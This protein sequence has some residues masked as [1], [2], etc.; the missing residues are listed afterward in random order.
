[1]CDR[2]DLALSVQFSV[3]ENRLDLI[4]DIW[5]LC[6]MPETGEFGVRIHSTL[7]CELGETL[8]ELGSELAL[9]DGSDSRCRSRE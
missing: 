5:A 2:E 6:L 8:F 3:G 1:M 7:R 4:L 9:C